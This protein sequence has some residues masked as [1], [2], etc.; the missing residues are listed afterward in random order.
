M[1]SNTFSKCVH[2]VFTFLIGLDLI[3]VVDKY[4]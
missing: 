4:Y 1:Y 2:F 3:R